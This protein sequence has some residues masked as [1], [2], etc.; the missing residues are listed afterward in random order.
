M[1]KVVILTVEDFMREED[2]RGDQSV[3]EIS[4]DIAIVNSGEEK[5]DSANEAWTDQE[6]RKVEG[7]RARVIKGFQI[8]GNRCGWH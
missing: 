6:G 7:T 5:G 1:F 8:L 2:I 4:K 3:A